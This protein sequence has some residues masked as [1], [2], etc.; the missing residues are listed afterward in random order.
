MTAYFVIILWVSDASWR[1]AVICTATVLILTIGLSRLYLGVHY[2]TDVIAGYA[3]GV[4]WLAS[5]VTGAEIARRQ[6]AVDSSP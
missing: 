4:V 2:F 6:P 5:C 1:S 3:A